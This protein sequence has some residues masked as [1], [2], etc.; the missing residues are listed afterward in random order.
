MLRRN[1]QTERGRHPWRRVSGI[2]EALVRGC[3]DFCS[4]LLSSPSSHQL[5]VSPSFPGSLSSLPS[6]CC[7]PVWVVFPR[8]GHGICVRA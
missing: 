2:W 5:W 6:F 3:V 7:V 1:C 8:E 4:C